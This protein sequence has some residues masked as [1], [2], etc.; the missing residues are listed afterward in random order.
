MVAAPRFVP[1]NDVTL[2]FG[3]LRGKNV[4][5]A[6]G[7]HGLENHLPQMHIVADIGFSDEG[8]CDQGSEKHVR[9]LVA[10]GC[11]F[12]SESVDGGT[13]ADVVLVDV[14]GGSVAVCYVDEDFV[15]G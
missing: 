13:D 15:A 12:G 3:F 7:V 2:P 6:L 4:V 5:P 8:V 9:T 10:E 1:F 14:V 11:S